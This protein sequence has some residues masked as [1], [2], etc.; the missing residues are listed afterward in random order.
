MEILKILYI[1]D[2]PE[3]SLSKY[4]DRYMNSSCD[5][6][7]S[8]I[9]FNPDEGYESLINNTEVKS[10]NIIFIDSK[11]FENRTA[12][13]GKFT[14]EEFKIILKKYFP[15]IEVIVITQNDIAPDYET[16]SKYDSKCG[17]TPEEYYGEKLSQILDQCIKNIFE[18][19]KI[20]S[21]MQKNTSWEKVMVEKIVNS[22]NGQGKFDELTKNDIDD[23][24]KM[25]QELQTKVEG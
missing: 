6:E 4:L 13:A 10:A 8:D 22:V 20:A 12:I 9:K 25:F 23:V 2:N 15:F 11:L 17:K 21:E 24:I 3:P 1:D 5:I 7:S 18:V 16:I 19:R 14:G